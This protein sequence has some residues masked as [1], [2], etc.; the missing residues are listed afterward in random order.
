MTVEIYRGKRLSVERKVVTLPGGSTRERLVVHPGDAVAVLPIR[1][2][3]CCYLIRQ[4]RFA[5][6]RSIC[7]VPAGTME[8]GE[9]PLET[10]H[11]ELIEETGM[12]ALTFIPRGFIFTTPGFTDE[13]IHLFE[14][15]GLTPSDAYHPDEDEV[16]ERVMIPLAEVEAMIADGRINDAKTICLV[17]RCTRG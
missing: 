12:Q 16:I 1:E 2:D 3:G 8:P 15:H 13:R 14:A 7:E 9:I 11:R 4:Y 10:A 6:D 5:L 17:H